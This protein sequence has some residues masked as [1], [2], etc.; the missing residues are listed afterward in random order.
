MGKDLGGEDGDVVAGVGLAGDMEVLVSILWELLEEK[1]EQSV[2]VLA[3]SNGVA[4]GAAT[5]GEADIDRLVE[6]DDRRVCIP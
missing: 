1:G 6:E 2:D 5:V 4:D 3:C